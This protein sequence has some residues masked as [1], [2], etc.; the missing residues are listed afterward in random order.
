M[1]RETSEELWICP[2]HGGEAHLTWTTLD[3]RAGY[4]VK[5]TISVD[6]CSLRM[7]GW[8]K[9]NKNGWIDD[10]EFLGKKELIE[11]WNRRIK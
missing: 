4:N 5:Y 1:V 8:S 7:T 10:P 6:C 11:S 2:L 3:E 9:S